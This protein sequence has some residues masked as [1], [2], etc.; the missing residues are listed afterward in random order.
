M[1]NQATFLFLIG[2]GCVCLVGSATGFFCL[3]P[4]YITFKSYVKTFYNFFSLYFFLTFCRRKAT[5]YM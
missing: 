4:Y 5:I 3:H 2:A 1:Y